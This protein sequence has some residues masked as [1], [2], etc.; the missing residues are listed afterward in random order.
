[1]I[2]ISFAQRVEAARCERARIDTFSVDA[3]LN[4]RTI[5][6]RAT[7]D[8]EASSLCVSGVAVPTDAH[9]SVGLWATVGV[10]SA[11]SWTGRARILAAFVDASF[12]VGTFA[13]LKTFRFGSWYFYVLQATLHFGRADVVR[14]TRTDPFVIDRLAEGVDAARVV[15]R[16]STFLVVTSLISGTVLVDDTF[17]ID[18]GRGSVYHAALSVEA[19][20]R[21]VARIWRRRDLFFTKGE[22][23]P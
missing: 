22:W 17:R 14:R 8:L 18:A 10:F 12:V 23:I 13:I 3:S 15:A 1:M 11:N 21:W 6:V 7:S 4:W 20:W 2:G 5:A 9:C 19:A 16:I